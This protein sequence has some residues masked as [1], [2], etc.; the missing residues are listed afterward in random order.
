MTNVIPFRP[1][2]PPLKPVYVE[3][4]AGTV[5]SGDHKGTFR[6]FVALVEANG[7]RLGVW[8]GDSYAEAKREAEETRSA[9]ELDAPIVDLTISGGSAA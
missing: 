4:D 2:P 6:F 8:D 9:L 5:I 3:I 1:K 7:R